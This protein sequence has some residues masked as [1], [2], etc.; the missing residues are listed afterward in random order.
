M[1]DLLLV[2]TIDFVIQIQED[3]DE[4]SDVEDLYSTLPME[5]VEALEDMVS[6]APSSLIKGVVAVSTT[7]VLSTKSPKATSPTQAT[8]STISQGTSQDQAEETTS[9][10]SNPEP[11]PDITY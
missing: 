1:V 10:E 4:F 11:V 9:I 8:V 5:K 2:L 6:L 3:F 7:A